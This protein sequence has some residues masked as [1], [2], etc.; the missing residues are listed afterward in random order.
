MLRDVG[1]WCVHIALVSYQRSPCGRRSSPNTLYVCDLWSAPLCLVISLIVA[2]AH[3]GWA[4]SR[5]RRKFL[6]VGQARSLAVGNRS[7]RVVMQFFLVAAVNSP[8]RVVAY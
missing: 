2:C 5:V 4:L 7:L 3:T 1:Q 8:H 6:L